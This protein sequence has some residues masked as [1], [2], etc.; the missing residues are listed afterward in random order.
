MSEALASGEPLP[1]IDNNDLGGDA[2]CWCGGGGGDDNGGDDDGGDDGGRD[3][4]G[5]DGGGDDGRHGLFKSV[6]QVAFS[7]KLYEQ[8]IVAANR[9][10]HDFLASEDGSGF[11]GQV[12]HPLIIFKNILSLFRESLKKDFLSHNHNYHCFPDSVWLSRSGL[13]DRGLRGKHSLLWRSLSEGDCDSL[14]RMK[15]RWLLWWNMGCH[16]TTFTFMG[17]AGSYYG[18][19]L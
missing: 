11:S 7:K 13:S 17:L 19:D 15:W 2:D 14:A 9:V 1:E 16:L 5:D 6:N 3:D 12:A 18:Y 10:Y 8:V 4:D